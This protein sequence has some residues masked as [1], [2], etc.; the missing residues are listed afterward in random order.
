MSTQGR[1]RVVFFGLSTFQALAMFRRGIFYSFLG[2]Y[3]RSYLGLSVTET[4]LFETIPMV[5]NI[6][7]QTFV[8]GR[9]T[10]RFQLRRSFVI[11]GELAAGLGHVVMFILHAGQAD[12]RAAGWVVIWG[13]TIIEVFWSMSN[14]GWSAFISDV[15]SPVE[16][17]AIQGKLASIGGLGRI[18]GALAGGAL[19]D[20]L[21]KAY[22]G[23]GYK[24]GGIFLLAAAVMVVSVIPMFFLPE[25]GIQK[26]GQGQSGKNSD[27]GASGTSGHMR[28]FAVFLVA[29]VLINSGVNSLA[30]IRGQYLD[31]REGFAASATQISLISN[32]ESLALILVGLSIGALGKRIG[33]Q[34]L[35]VLGAAF[36]VLYLLAYT[37]AP[38]LWMIYPASLMRG[39]SDGFLA[40]S[41][42]A[43][44]SVLI[45]PE[46]RGRYF[47][48][49]NATFM[50]SWGTS[51]TLVTGPV[52]DAV[53]RTG[54]HPV[55]A[56]R[57]GMLTSAVTSMAGLGILVTLLLRMRKTR[58]G[59]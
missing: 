37:V 54:G 49:Y 29:M 56:Y 59:A 46:K 38:G 25:G 30:A 8:W 53:L 19:Y 57:V 41:S 27:A 22:P 34:A 17:N 52:I 11:A 7:F 1:P 36:G 23:W 32:I 15:Y 51:A 20:G 18:I 26:S 16:R 24:E 50:L 44:A 3:L 4:T 14:I 45:P 9:L 13:L 28:V 55:L 12:P 31:L 40:A 33:V 42:Y 21:G 2:I 6:L 10:D 35:M 5:G 48:A 39:L 58:A 47:A 43:F